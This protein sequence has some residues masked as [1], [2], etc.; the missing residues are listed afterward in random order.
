MVV[1]LGI[2]FGRPIGRLT[3][4]DKSQLLQNI[5]AHE[6]EVKQFVRH[7]T[8]WTQGIYHLGSITSKQLWLLV[9]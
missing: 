9:E 3:A 1:L 4:A 7:H 2:E 8:E 6:P 5:D